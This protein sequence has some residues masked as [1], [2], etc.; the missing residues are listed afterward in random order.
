[1]LKGDV[2]KKIILAAFLVLI[3]AVAVSATEFNDSVVPGLNI[4]TDIDGALA[5]AQSQG[6]NVILIFDQESCYYCVLLKENVLSDGD[7]Q[8]QLNENF[9]VVIVDINKQPDVADKYNI[10]GTPECVILNSVG[11][12]VKKI[13]GYVGNAEF[14]DAIKGV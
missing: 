13:D 12:E 10:Y 14:L 6:K 1:M 2:M 11:E 5:D 8:K 4:T 9:I 7:V 3:M